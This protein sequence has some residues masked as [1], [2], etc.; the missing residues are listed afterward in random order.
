M[1]FFDVTVAEISYLCS[2]LFWLWY[3]WPLAASP[4]QKKGA[5]SSA[6]ASAE[7]TRN[8]L[9]SNAQS[10]QRLFLRDVLALGNPSC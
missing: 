7:V 2:V 10:V 3:S 9:Q 4:P 5:G 1:L 8:K 6:G